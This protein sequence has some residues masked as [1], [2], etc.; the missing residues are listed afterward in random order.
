MSNPVT[1]QYNKYVFPF[2]SRYLLLDSIVAIFLIGALIGLGAL[3]F[4]LAPDS[5]DFEGDIL[6]TYSLYILSAMAICCMTF[7]R[8]RRQNIPV[9]PLSRKSW[10]GNISW[11]QV[12]II[13]YAD[14]GVTQGIS[15]INLFYINLVSPETTHV[16]LEGIDIPIRFDFSLIPLFIAIVIVAPLAEEFIFRGVLFQRWSFK[17]GSTFGFVASSVVFGLVHADYFITERIAGGAIYAMAYCKTQT[18]FIPIVLH[19]ANNFLALSYEIIATMTQTNNDTQVTLEYLWHGLV[20]LALAFPAIIYFLWI[21]SRLSELPY[22][23][24]QRLQ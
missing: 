6:L 4:G 22:M 23:R 16:A 2:K 15:Y 13:F 24:H 3:A 8:L 5:L 1:N 9:G 7:G 10:I 12:L 21:P 20:N 17:W 14:L 11:L 19:A 18:L